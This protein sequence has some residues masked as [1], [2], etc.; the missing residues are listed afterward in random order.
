MNWA[1][2]PK[3]YRGLEARILNE[4]SPSIIPEGASANDANRLPIMMSKY[5]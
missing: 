3:T 2:P 5:R 1:A 4:A